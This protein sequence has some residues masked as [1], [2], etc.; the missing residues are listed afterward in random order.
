MSVN[1]ATVENLRDMASR[2]RKLNLAQRRLNLSVAWLRIF[3]TCVSSSNDP[4]AALEAIWAQEVARQVYFSM[5]GVYRVDGGV[6]QPL[7][8]VGPSALRRLPELALDLE[9]LLRQP[10]GVS[11]DDEPFPFVKGF[12]I[13][14]GAWCLLDK[15]GGG[16]RLFLAG[17]AE[18]A[19]RFADL[20]HA[21]ALDY[22]RMTGQ[23]VLLLAEQKE[24]RRRLLREHLELS[25][26]H[27]ELRARDDELRRN[28]ALLEERSG[29]LE[30][31]LDRLQRAQQDRVHTER[32]TAIGQLAA[33]VAHEV[34]NP[35]SFVLS[36]LE[37]LEEIVARELEGD[38]KARGEAL[39]TEALQGL[40]HII[41]IIRELG[42]FSRQRE[43]GVTNLEVNELA[44]TVVRLAGAHIKHTATVDLEL[45]ADLRARGDHQQ[46]VQI[47]L[48]LLINAAQAFPDEN[49]ARNRVPV[50][51]WR[52]AVHQRVVIEVADN[53]GGI[54]EDIAASIF[55]PF[56]TTKSSTGP[57]SGGT[58]LGLSIGADLAR[59]NGGALSLARTGPEGSAFEL[60]LPMALSDFLSNPVETGLRA[61]PIGEPVA[62]RR[63]KVLLVDDDPR[64]MRA[65]RRKLDPQFEVDE[66]VGGMQGL[67][68]LLGAE[69]YDAVVCDLMMP[70]LHGLE[71]RERVLAERPEYEQ[72][73]ILV[74]GGVARERDRETIER[75]GLA[76]VRKPVKPEAL[77]ERI[78]GV[79]GGAGGGGGGG[80]GGPG[81]GRGAGAGGGG[82]GYAGGA[83]RAHF[84]WG[85]PRGL[86]AA[87]A[88]GAP[89]A[90]QGPLRGGWGGFAAGLPS[91]S[92]TSAPLR[93]RVLRASPTSAPLR[94]RVLRTS[95]TSAPLRDRFS[96][97]HSPPRLAPRAAPGC[98]GTS[99]TRSA[100]RGA[101]LGLGASP[102]PSRRGGTR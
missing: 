29:E 102:A 4:N 9:A 1:P 45:D 63:L 31:A 70:D 24:S 77:I 15:P 74:S 61:L 26:V 96:A 51:G 76:V 68:K 72:R 57:N 89:S 52:D 73:L 42:R 39:V 79:A 64:V 36:D 44:L 95:P 59:R 27:R 84:R 65:H 5:A 10:A 80:G 93:D 86:L 16:L 91:T 71:L 75:L 100:A 3:D 14:K 67:A 69:H 62:N 8:V 66:A 87:P 43:V 81:G 33:G 6:A 83:A 92:P 47:L 34:N 94:D 60:T 54:P 55:E 30:S 99:L 58:G 13:H 101:L 85:A 48:N 98:P 38:A 20:P 49:V 32:L 25:R 90:R 18:R 56:F 37:E 50:R 22:L 41:G 7:A 23:S 2:E 12:A 97:P 35:A 17:H 53:A 21:E 78:Y 28:N 88:A 11:L 40:N 82:A 46:I 19:A